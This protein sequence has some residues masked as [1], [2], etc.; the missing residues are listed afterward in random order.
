MNKKC[1]GSLCNYGVPYESVRL[2]ARGHVIIVCIKRMRTITQCY[3]PWTGV[4]MIHCE[5]CLFQ[6]ATNCLFKQV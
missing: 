6:T 3:A 4:L 2:L 1:I 5:C